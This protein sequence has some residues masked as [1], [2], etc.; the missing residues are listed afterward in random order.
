MNENTSKFE[1]FHTGSFAIMPIA[2]MISMISAYIFSPFII[3]LYDILMFLSC[4]IILC[5][6]IYFRRTVISLHNIFK[7]ILASFCSASFALILILIN[8]VISENI[9]KYLGYIGNTGEIRDK[10]DIKVIIAVPCIVVSLIWIF[11]YI[12]FLAQKVCMPS[13]ILVIAK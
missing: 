10:G 4:F 12:V 11:V 7:S 9:I 8:A 2:I 6:W 5:A 13:E 1:F 3:R